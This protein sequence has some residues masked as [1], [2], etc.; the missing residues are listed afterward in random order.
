MCASLDC[1]SIL[2]FGLRGPCG[3]MCLSSPWRVGLVWLRP[4]GGLN[5]VAKCGRNTNHASF[6]LSYTTTIEKIEQLDQQPN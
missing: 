3:E 1:L 5:N 4:I 6:T 2:G